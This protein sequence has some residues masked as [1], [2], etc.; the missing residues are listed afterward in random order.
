MNEMDK[1]RALTCLTGLMYFPFVL[2]TDHVAGNGANISDVHH[3]Y[4]FAD[5]NVSAHDCQYEDTNA[6]LLGLQVDKAFT[7][8]FTPLR[9]GRAVL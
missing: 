7:A 5:Q 8:P 9:K 1:N 2:R 3:I 4:R 6:G